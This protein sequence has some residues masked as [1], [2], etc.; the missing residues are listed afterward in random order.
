MKTKNQNTKSNLHSTFAW[1]RPHLA[2]GLALV[3]LT[4]VVFEAGALRGR[5][6]FTGHASLTPLSGGQVEMQINVAGNVTHLGKST[7]RIHSVADFSGPIPT[8]IPP[9]TGVIT[10]ANGDTVT[11]RLRWSVLEVA[12]GAYQT[13]G[14]F[15]ITGGTGRF[16]NASGAGDYR[17]LVD[18]NSGDVTADIAGAL[19][20]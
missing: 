10:A 16:N 13:S 8:P 11:F 5:G 7:V 1:L 9:T 15:D 20:R 14:P 6:S 17:G 18:I 3:C 2:L 12:P 4:S 19:A